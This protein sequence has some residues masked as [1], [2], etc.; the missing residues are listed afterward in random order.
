MIDAYNGILL[1]LIKEENS[2]ICNTLH[3]PRGCY[4]KWNKPEKGQILFYH[5]EFD[6]IEFVLSLVYFT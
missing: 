4:A 2:S 5:I 6:H 1:C 3:G